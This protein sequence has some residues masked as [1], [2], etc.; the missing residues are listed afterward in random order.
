MPPIVYRYEAAEGTAQVRSWGELQTLLF[1]QQL[2]D[3]RLAT[4][5]CPCLLTLPLFSPQIYR[6]LYPLQPLRSGDLQWDGPECVEGAHLDGLKTCQPPKVRSSL[7]CT[8]PSASRPAK[9]PCAQP[10]L[11]S[12]AGCCAPLVFA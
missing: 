4:C 3:A 10:T 7:A 12:A 11:R 9:G 5:P 2:R 6:A 1:K 8:P